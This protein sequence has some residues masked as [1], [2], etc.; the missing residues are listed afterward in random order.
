MTSTNQNS[1]SFFSVFQKTLVGFAGLS[2]GLSVG[3]AATDISES[4]TSETLPADWT[5]SYYN[6]TAP[7]PNYAIDIVGVGG[8]IDMLRLQRYS[9]HAA[10]S[11]VAY[12]YTG[13]TGDVT[14]GVLGDFSATLNV[15]TKQTS[16]Q[17]ASTQGVMVGAQSTTYASTG[18]YVAYDLDGLYIYENPTSHTSNGTLRDSDA[19]DSSILADT[20]YELGISVNGNEL[21]ASLSSGATELGTVSYTAGADIEGLFGVRSAFG[22]SGISAYFGDVE[23]TAIPEPSSFALLGA[24]G[25]LLFVVSRRSVR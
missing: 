9:G 4:F 21:I 24:M 1:Y 10:A 2:L 22:N 7:D 19:F 17:A 15:Q 3:T 16:S 23:I 20:T 25:A 13:T 5:D 6:G 11:N 18:F 12:Y 8:G 14:N